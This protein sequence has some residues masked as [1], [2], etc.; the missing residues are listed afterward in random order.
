MKHP[1][2]G[3]SSLKNAVDFIWMREQRHVEQI[4]EIKQVLGL[5]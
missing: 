3:I 5:E 2:F 4:V 1:A